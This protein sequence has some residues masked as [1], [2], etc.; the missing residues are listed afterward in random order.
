MKGGGG[1][2][3]KYKRY[4]F[5]ACYI[6]IH[7]IILVNKIVFYNNSVIKAALVF[8]A[9]NSKILKIHLTISPLLS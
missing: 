3:S 5:V 1:D 4:I 8:R 7:L 9:D 2:L 6:P